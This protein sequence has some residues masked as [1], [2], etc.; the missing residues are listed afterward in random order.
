[1]LPLVNYNQREMILI[2]KKSK[3]NFWLHVIKL[4]KKSRRSFQVH[5]IYRFNVPATSKGE[6]ELGDACQSTAEKFDKLTKDTKIV[7][8]LL[9]N[10]LNQQNILGGAKS[11][12]ST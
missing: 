1:M 7:A 9:N 6:N 11:V 3:M 2:L 10:L 8:S 4:L 5:F 12:C